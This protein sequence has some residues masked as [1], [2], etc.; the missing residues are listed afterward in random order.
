M[1]DYEG[2]PGPRYIYLVEDD[3]SLRSIMRGMLVGPGIQIAEFETGETFL[4]GYSGRPPGCV[5]LDVNLPGMG[6]LEVLERIAAVPP[7]NAIIMVSGFGDIPSAVRAVKMGAADFVQKPFRREQ[8]VALVDKAFDVVEAKTRNSRQLEA[9]TPREREVL[10]AFREGEQNKVVAARLG[11]SP[12]TVEM[13][14]ARLFAKLG[15]MN[16]SQALLRAKE[17]GLI[18]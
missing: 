12:R 1:R 17:A 13:Y 11:L 6:G 9:L 16:L 7:R 4:D 2:A 8:L 15:V 14:R 3:A 18:S 5:I 10:I